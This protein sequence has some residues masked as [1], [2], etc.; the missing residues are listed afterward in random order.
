M[1]EPFRGVRGKMIHIV[2]ISTLKKAVDEGSFCHRASDEFNAR[3]LRDIFTETPRKV[4]QHNDA[5]CRQ[6]GVRE[7]GAD[8][9]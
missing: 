6:A 7:N 1:T 9:V 2:K 8:N 5:I 3:V 4:I